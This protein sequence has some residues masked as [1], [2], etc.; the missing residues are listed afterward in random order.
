MKESIIERI[1]ETKPGETICLNHE[2][3][4]EVIRMISG[5]WNRPDSPPKE[6]GEYMVAVIELEEWKA[7]ATREYNNSTGW[8]LGIHEKLIGWM[9]LPGFPERGES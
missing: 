6:T 5:G 7:V 4:K 9:P 8:Q 3:C 1:R 2:E